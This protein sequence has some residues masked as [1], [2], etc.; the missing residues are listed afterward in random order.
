MKKKN[1]AQLFEENAEKVDNILGALGG[2]TVAEAADLL[3]E[4]AKTLPEISMVKIA[5][6]YKNTEN[7]H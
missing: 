3:C 2:L 4:I 7:N 6:N 5:E 1:R